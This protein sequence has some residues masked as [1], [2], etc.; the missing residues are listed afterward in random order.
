MLHATPK[1]N[2]LSYNDVHIYI[3]T[4]AQNLKDTNTP[5]LQKSV[6]QEHAANRRSMN[7]NR[8]PPNSSTEAS[9]A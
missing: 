3:S 9:F 5:Q 1:L 4:S 7:Q 8:S 6:W 2:G